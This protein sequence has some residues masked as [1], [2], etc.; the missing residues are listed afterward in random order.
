M[1]KINRKVRIAL[2]LAAGLAVAVPAAAAQAESPALEALRDRVEVAVRA[3]DAAALEAARGEFLAG[4]AAEPAGRD[5]YY[6]AYVRFRQGQLAAGEA[7]TARRHLDDCIRELEAYVARQPADAEA[8]AL[9]GSCYGVSTRYNKLA[10]AR[11]GLE[12]RRHMAAA[13]ELAPQNPWVVMQDAMADFATPRLFGGDRDLAI[14]K[15]ERATGLFAGAVE[16]GSRIA[17]WG[18]AE[19][20][21]Q[22][23]GMYRDAGRDADARLALERAASLAPRRDTR[24]AA[25]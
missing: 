2:A 3:G 4:A 9:L 21:L 7:A 12:A 1:G 20:W 15:L 24:L 11:R 6:A 14:T 19:A 13:R 5:A 22:L 10:L 18:A 23:G 8:R 25:L 17:A 16:A